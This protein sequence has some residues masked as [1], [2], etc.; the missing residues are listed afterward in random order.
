[1]LPMAQFIQYSMYDACVN[2]GLC[3]DVY[4][5]IIHGDYITHKQ[6]KGPP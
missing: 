1:M 5:S 2:L 3:G 4:H 6:W